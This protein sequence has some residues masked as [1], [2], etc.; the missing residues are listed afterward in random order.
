[1]PL[2]FAETAPVVFHK[3]PAEVPETIVLGAADNETIVGGEGGIVTVM[4]SVFVTA[5]PREFAAVSV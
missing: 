1:V 3:I 5:A 4:V 2:S